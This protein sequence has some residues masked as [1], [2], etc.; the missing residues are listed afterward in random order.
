MSQATLFEHAPPRHT[1]VRRAGAQLEIPEAIDT[2]PC[3]HGMHRFAGKF[4]PNVPRYLLRNA[5][6][7]DS[8]RI[9]FDPFCGSGTTL[10][11]AALEGRP[12]LGMD[13]DPL[14]VL[15]SRAKTRCLS[16]EEL[17][18]VAHFWRNHDFT[19]LCPDLIPPVP[20]LSHWFSPK[21][22]IQLA[23][24]KARCIQLPE[25]LRTF[26]LVVM[27]SVIR[28]AS[29]AD[30]QT[31]KTYVSHT[32]PKTPPLP[33]V[34]FPEFLKRAISAM[35]DYGASLPCPP[36]GHVFA[37]DART[38]A[39]SL[40]FRDVLT[41]PPYIDSVDYVYNTMLEYFWL[42]PELGIH[43]YD[44]YRVFRKIPMGFTVRDTQSPEAL[45]ADLPTDAARLL[46]PI[47]LAISQVSP[48]EARVVLSYFADLYQHVLAIRNAQRLGDR[49][50]SILGN[51]TIRRVLVPTAEVAIALFESAGY[52]LADRMFYEIRRHYM[53]FP[54]RSNSG[55]IARDHILI[56]EV[57]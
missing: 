41:S 55:K 46:A 56:F 31:Q 13:L 52:A 39:G 20:N 42:L 45:L 2:I 44:R 32:L 33:A 40:Q 28:R 30:D 12:F 51:S 17:S 10:V 11:E 16:R 47:Y 9:V 53:K 19:A 1:H 27:S 3:T 25:D 34:L 23:S 5:L 7:N 18:E 57:P 24:I 21:A 43:S 22:V 26:S 6:N 14:A 50:I 36:Q 48:R 8:S 54:R 37:G 38:I 4:I 49:Y 35:R 29:N 15:I